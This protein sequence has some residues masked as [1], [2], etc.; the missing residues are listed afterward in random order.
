VL[1][2]LVKFALVS[3]VLVPLCFLLATGIR[4]L[5]GARRIL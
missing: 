3:L 5:P 2:P 1:Y 4:R